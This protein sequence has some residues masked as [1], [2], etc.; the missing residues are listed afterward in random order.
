MTDPVKKAQAQPTAPAVKKTEAKAQD[1]VPLQNIFDVAAKTPG[2]ELASVKKLIEKQS[3]FNQKEES[4][5]NLPNGGYSRTKTDANGSIYKE[6]YS[7]PYD[8][9]LESISLNVKVGKDEASVEYKKQKDAKSGDNES[10]KLAR[11]Y[12]DGRKVESRFDYKGVKDG[13]PAETLIETIDS[14]KYGEI[15]PRR[16]GRVDSK[17]RTHHYVD[18]N[19]DGRDE[20]NESEV[21]T[22]GKYFAN[23]T[24]KDH[25]INNSKIVVSLDSN[26]KR[27]ED[28]FNLHTKTDIDDGKETKKTQ[29]WDVHIDAKGQYS[30]KRE[31]KKGDKTAS[32]EYQGYHTKSE[33]QEVTVKKDG[34]IIFQ[35]IPT[36]K[37]RKEFLDID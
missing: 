20:L 28:H 11:Q 1:L 34:K 25:D 32:M 30:Y 10:F 36:E 18:A 27:V 23:G 16:A 5:E 29:K 37:Q 4:I 8:R 19:R 31:T 35:G 21:N 7:S 33:E 17:T 12:P 9:D 15:A 13:K 3:V 22:E 2:A 14:K 24:L 26:G 6:I